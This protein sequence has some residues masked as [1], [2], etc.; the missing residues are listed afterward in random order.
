MCFQTALLFTVFVMRVLLQPVR[1]DCKVNGKCMF[2]AVDIAL[3][4]VVVLWVTI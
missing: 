2:S 3:I 1:V 4:V